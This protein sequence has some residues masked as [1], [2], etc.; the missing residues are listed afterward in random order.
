MAMIMSGFTGGQ[1][2]ELRR[3]MGFKRADKRLAKIEQNLREGMSKNDIAEEIQD[4]IVQN[5]TAFANY[6]FP[7]SH[8]ASFALLAYASAYLKVYYLA[9]FTTAMLN[10]YPLG[11]YVPATLIKD[12]QRH[13][14]HFRHVD[15]NRSDYLFTI[16]D[17]EVRI[18]LKYIKGLRQEAAEAIVAARD[19]DGNYR[20]VEDLVDRVP[21][22]NK[23]EI[24]ALSLAGGLNFEKQVHRRQALWQSEIAIQPNGELFAKAKSDERNP[25]FIKSMTEWQAMESDL[26]TMAITVGKHPMAFLRE[27]LKKRGVLSAIET[28]GLPKRELVTVAGSV[29]VRQRPSTGN[30]VV[31]I[32]MEDET[33]H[34]NFIVMPDIFERFRRIITHNS[35][36]LIKGISEEG[37]M[38]K[39]L[40]FEP[41]NAFMAEIGSHD[42]H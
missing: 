22:I 37:N 2:E 3:A 35:F 24:R 16:E 23:K 34:S 5:I 26:R 11:F 27:D 4:R 25:D 17:G 15:V 18:G 32:T 40:Y 20:S 33:G 41:I 9:E 29:I 38:I 31:F 7:E 19:A 30:S 28:H 21:V 42:F 14:L 8:A 1:A 36:L 39:A 12:A 6:G 10:N 13:G